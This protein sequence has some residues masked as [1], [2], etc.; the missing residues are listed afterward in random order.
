MYYPIIYT[1]IVLTI[2]SGLGILLPWLFTKY[3]I[4]STDSTFLTDS[5]ES[6]YTETYLNTRYDNAC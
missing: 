1:I 5:R 6:A 4:F 3:L 2:A